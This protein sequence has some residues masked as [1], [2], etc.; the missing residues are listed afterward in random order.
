MAPR[1]RGRFFIS[2]IPANK[3][4]CRGASNIYHGKSMAPSPVTSIGAA[5]LGAIAVLLWR[6]REGRTPVTARKILIPPAGMATGFCMFVVPMFRVP[7]LWALIAFLLGALLLA[8]PLTRT[9]SLQ[10][11]GDQIMMQRS[12][13][14]FGRNCRAGIDPPAGAQLRR[15][16]RHAGADGRDLLHPCVWHDPAVAYDDVPAVPAT[17]GERLSLSSGI[18]ASD[19]PPHARAA[20]LPI[21]R[22]DD[23]AA[24]RSLRLILPW[25]DCHEPQGRFHRLP[26]QPQRAPGRG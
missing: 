3:P 22:A 24:A 17:H 8:E 12:K 23:P 1:P 9:S 5:L 21:R 2:H 13:A 11:V 26:R 20:V 6:I 14:F 4:Q 7:W 10:R 25:P 19:S 16:V 15:P 18:K